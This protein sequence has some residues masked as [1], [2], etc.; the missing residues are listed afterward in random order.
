M[1]PFETL[2]LVKRTSDEVMWSKWCETYFS[3]CFI[4]SI[5]DFFLDTKICY[6]YLYGFLVVFALKQFPLMTTW[7]SGPSSLLRESEW[8]PVL[9]LK[10]SCVHVHI[11]SLNMWRDNCWWQLIIHGYIVQKPPPVFDFSFNRSNLSKRSINSRLL[12]F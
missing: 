8:E 10:K 9:S 4:W 3:P 7:L 2:S 11:Q 1:R 5:R 6:E 12:I